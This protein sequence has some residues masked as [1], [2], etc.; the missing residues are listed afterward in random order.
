M[1]SVSLAVVAFLCPLLG[2]SVGTTPRSRL[3][4]YHLGR[5]STD[6]IK[7][8]TGLVATL[9]ALVLS[10]LILSAN[11]TRVAAPASAEQKWFQSQALQLTHTVSQIHR[12]AIR[13]ETSAEPP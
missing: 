12:L 13:Q 9:V 11:S 10:L 2:A 5:E 7:L 1:S 3:P 4:E 6:A 8:A